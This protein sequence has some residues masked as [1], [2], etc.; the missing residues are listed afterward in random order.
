[1]LPP[2]FASASNRNA[3]RPFTGFEF[4]SRMQ[5]VISFLGAGA[6]AGVGPGAG[7][8]AVPGVPGDAVAPPPG[9]IN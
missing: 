7:V 1:M 4:T 9:N 5:S 6:G 8:G 3:A 2:C